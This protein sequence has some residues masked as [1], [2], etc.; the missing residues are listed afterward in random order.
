M[1]QDDAHSD[2]SDDD[3]APPAQKTSR[4]TFNKTG[5]RTNK[6]DKRLPSAETLRGRYQCADLTRLLVQNT[7]YQKE[8]LN[9]ASHPILIK[10]VLREAELAPDKFE[11]IME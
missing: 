3:D 4:P 7:K 9:R 5:A 1:L 8:E 10:M 6:S 2:S 11:E